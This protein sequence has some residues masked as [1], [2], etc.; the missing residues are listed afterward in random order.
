MSLLLGSGLA[1]NLFRLGHWAPLPDEVNYALSAHH[2]I[3]HRTLLGQDIM[4]FP[5]LFVYLSALLQLSGAGLLTSVRLVSAVF[6]AL[7][8]PMLYLTLRSLYD[9]RTAGLTA[10]AT[11]L[12]FALHLYSRLG[13][14]EI[15]MLTLII[16]G[17]FLLLW[18]M[19]TG[20]SRYAFWSGVL[21]GFALWAK[22]TALGVLAA[23]LLFLLVVGPRPKQ[24]L[25]LLMVGWLL[26]ATPLILLGEL[27]G[28]SLL[29]EVST[30]RGYD[31]NMLRLSPFGNLLTTGANLGYNLFP[32]LFYR[33]EFVLF[34]I[35]APLTM[36]ALG[37]ILLQG[38][39][40][41]RPFPLFVACYL[42]IH[43]PFF[44]LF[45]RKFDYY[46]LPAAVLLLTSGV[47]E[48]L[49]A[50]S[51]A[52]TPGRASRVLRPVALGLAALLVG[53]N[54]YS[55]RFLYWN[56]GTHQTFAAAVA[57]L[58]PN[59]GLATSHPS[60]ARYISDRCSLNLHVVPL[61]GDGDY[62][63]RWDTATTPST[64]AVVMKRY[65]FDV[66]AEQPDRPLDSLTSV[67]P[68]RHIMT[69]ADWSVWFACDFD[70]N[71]NVTHRLTQHLLRGI[72][73]VGVVILRR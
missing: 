4:F 48:A 7:I 21:F 32:R 8:P 58:D 22:E 10:S 6:G 72:R 73:P 29:L 3:E 67:F 57:T 52:Q 2:L 30:A 9:D 34:A 37:W 17:I 39:I 15:L 13:Q 61:F 1:L 59:T 40:R 55:W 31:I 51:P 14:V 28:H 69:D 43:L 65:Y 44:F 66:L 11:L 24:N 47:A 27:S 53:F 16:G 33:W 41:K 54:L 45:S 19:R 71:R 70:S 62:E 60:L 49:A 23:A 20:R 25:A 12:L 26:P 5:P 35:A 18:G 56:R 68:V 50:R 36:L 46:L 63:I 64:R 42:A 38:T